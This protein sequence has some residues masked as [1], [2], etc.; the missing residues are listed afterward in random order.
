MAFRF[1]D[2]SITISTGFDGKEPKAVVAVMGDTPHFALMQFG[3]CAASTQRECNTKPDDIKLVEASVGEH[4]D[5]NALRR[6]LQ[7][8]LGQ[9]DPALN[10]VQTGEVERNPRRVLPGPEPER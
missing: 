10:Q 7:D 8:L 2:L 3:T 9:L 6:M 1:Q 5:L 4:T